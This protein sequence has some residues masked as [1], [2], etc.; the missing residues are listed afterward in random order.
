[1]YH[2]AGDPRSARRALDTPAGFSPE[3]TARVALGRVRRLLDAYTPGMEVERTRLPEMLAAAL[4]DPALERERQFVLGWLYWLNDD[5]IGA[6][7]LFGEAM[8]R[9]HEENALEALAESAYW[10]AR[11][12]LL[13]GHGEAL[14][15]FEGVLRTLGGSPRATAW[16][17][18]LLGRAGR[19]DR[20]EQVWKSVRG[21]KRVAGCAEGPLLEARMLLRRGELT[22]AERALNEAT[23]SSGVVWVERLLLLAWIAVSQKQHERAS[24]LLQQAR[25]GPYPPA[26]LETWTARIA[27]HGRGEAEAI[28]EAGRTPVALRDYRSGQEARRRGE[29]EQAIA[30]YRAALGSPA[31]QPFARYALA[32][33]GQ[34]DLAGLLASQPGLF[35]AV[36]CR[37]RLA[38]ER[39]CRREASPAEYL[40][41]LQQAAAAGYQDAAAEH[42]RRLAAALHERQPDTARVRELA[43]DA[44]TDAAAR[45]RFRVAVELAMRRLPAAD[46][47]V[48]LL[49]WSRRDDLKES[50]RCLVG[51]QLL[52]LLLLEDPDDAEARAAVSRLRPEEP[53]LALMNVPSSPAFAMGERLTAEPAVR[54]WQAAQTL[55]P[56]SGEPERWR[57]EVRSVRSHARWKGLAQALLVQEAA[58]RGDGTA[59]LALLDEVDMWRGLCRPPAFVLRALETIVAAQP[60]HPGWRRSLTRWL[61]L[62]DLASP[63]AAATTLATQAGLAPL[64]GDT[65]EA[66]P[67]VPAV[68]WLLHQAARALGR[69]DA[70]D[71]LAFMRRA[72][73]LDPELGS[74]A[75]A[76]AVRDAL[77]ELERRARAQNLASVLQPEGESATL[78]AG[79]LADAVDALAAVPAGAAALNALASGDRE[80][81][82]GRLEALSEQA[83]LPPGLA[84]HLALL[85]Q[86]AADAR[87]PHEDSASAEPYRRRSWRCWLCYLGG[88]DSDTRRIVLDYLLERH[89]HRINDL[90]ARNAVGAARRHWN[91]VREVPTWA[92]QAEESLRQDLAQRIERFRDELA[93]E[94]LLTTREAMRFG[95]MPEGWRADYEKGLTYLRRLLSL[96]RDNPRLLAALIEICNDW[97]LDLYHLGDGATLRAQVERFTPFALQ[98]ARR[99]DER[100]G[101]LSGR[102]AL[103][104]FWK[105]RGFVTGDRTQKAALYREA[106]R[107][108]PANRNVQDL[109]ADLESAP[110]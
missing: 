3:A 34:D 8:R 110:Q 26:A 31:A 102:A 89:R 50:L 33:L 58:Q 25:E 55:D 2:G 72:L 32:C 57:D 4:D 88:A 63:G 109:L 91:L 85:M 52:R 103:A 13:R 28:E 23:P 98:L 54:L 78:A 10:S 17:V 45:N 39:F 24:E 64:R 36:R 53:L 6:E 66:P 96:D 83:D 92:A 100:P 5:P 107:F 44:S 99:I 73:A 49:E 61:P 16:F 84:H 95:A 41:A 59:V 9:A 90:L 51:R 29:M 75:D 62:W 82:R 101:D 79:V 30:A 106:L 71:A 20:V 19:V 27:Q 74:L 94:Y 18:D 35:L 46:A 68:P 70:L 108:N 97:F 1:M 37:A 65:A 81:A 60:G 7:P 56:A 12:R 40:D 87:E 48:L 43:A 104:D 15:E 38:Q 69:D 42:F 93:T 80:A 67:G 11:V 47:R 22:P 86:R 77:P 76:Q 14:A 105:F 21:N